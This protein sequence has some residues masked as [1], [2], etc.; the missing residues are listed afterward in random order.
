MTLIAATSAKQNSLPNY[1]HWR[2]STTCIISLMALI[3]TTMAISALDSGQHVNL[4][5]VVP[6]RKLVWV[7]AKYG[8]WLAYWG[9]LSGTN[10]RW[11]ASHRVFLMEIRLM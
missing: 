3:K 8:P 10:Q 9:Y 4:V 1:N 7:N 2:N 5:F 6:L 11:L